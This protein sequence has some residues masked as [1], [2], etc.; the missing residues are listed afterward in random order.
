VNLNFSN[1][2]VDW[3][4]QPVLKNQVYTKILSI[5]P[6]RPV[7]YIL[8]LTLLPYSSKH[9]WKEFNTILLFC[10]H[11]EMRNRQVSRRAEFRKYLG[12]HE[13]GELSIICR[14]PV[15]AECFVAINLSMYCRPLVLF[16]VSFHHRQAKF[17]ES[18]PTMCNTSSHISWI[19]VI[20]GDQTYS[21]KI[22]SSPFPFV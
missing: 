13:G 21:V 8:V 4:E 3:L 17:L 11:V 19:V 20:I 12:C 6:P 16:N 9:E 18:Y 10:C 5:R 22:H 14:H 7:N 1:H 2:I 15:R